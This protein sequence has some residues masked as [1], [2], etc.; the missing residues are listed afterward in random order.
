MKMFSRS[1]ALLIGI[2]AAIGIIFATAPVAD[3]ATSVSDFSYSVRNKEVLLRITTGKAR[4]SL[5]RGT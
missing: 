5:S 1:A 3:A 2:V 4:M